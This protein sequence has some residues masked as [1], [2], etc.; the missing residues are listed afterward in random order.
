MHTVVIDAGPD[1][2]YQMLC[3]KVD[4]LDALFITHEHNDHIIGLDDVRPFIFRQQKEL[5]IYGLARV[6]SDIRKR[7]AYAFSEKKYP[8]VPRFELHEL[9]DGASIELG[10]IRI[11]AVKLWHGSLD[12]LGYIINEKLA[13]FTDTNRVPPELIEEIKGIEIL[14]LDALHHRI[15]H[16]HFNLDQ[17]IACARSINPTVCYLTHISHTMGPTKIWEQ[18]L[19]SNVFPSFDGLGFDLS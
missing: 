18:N 5:P 12:I 7:F 6:L 3:Q 9:S 10:D 17:A 19:P 16:S 1:F 15:H 11:R 14:I 2:R 13:Y 4:R 8:G